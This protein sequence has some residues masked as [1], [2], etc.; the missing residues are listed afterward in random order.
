MSR[1]CK[2]SNHW[3]N[4]RR[5]VQSI[6]ARIANARRDFLHKATT[7]I[8]QN[9]ARNLSRSARGNSEVPGKAVRS[10]CGLNK[11]IFDKG[12]FEFRRQLAYR[13]DWKGGVLVAVPPHNTSRTCPACGH[14]AQQN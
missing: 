9:H 6:H 5:R 12:W 4:A 3:H 8:S 10:K 2:F 14:V 1:K 13:L 7:T 11:S